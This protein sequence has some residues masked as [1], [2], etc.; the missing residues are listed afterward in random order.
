[1][2]KILKNLKESWLAVLVIV[3][4]LCVQAATDLKLPEFTSQIVNVGI[5][6]GGIENAYPEVIRKSTL[7]SMRNFTDNYNKI[8]NSYEKIE[9]TDKNIDNYPR[10]KR[11]GN[12]YN[13]RYFKKGKR[14][15]K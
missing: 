7:E 6:Q 5:Q 8:A 10:S 9:K 4:L 13:K 15:I 2:L 14:R 3:L 12:L 11:R 1:M